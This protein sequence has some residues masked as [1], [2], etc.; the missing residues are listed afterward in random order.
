MKKPPV[1]TFYMRQVDQAAFAFS[2]ASSLILT[3]AV[4]ALLVG[5]R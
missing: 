3:I 1:K 5:A 4:A 2:I